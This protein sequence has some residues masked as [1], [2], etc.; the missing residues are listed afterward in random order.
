MTG[1]GNRARHL[2]SRAVDSMRCNRFSFPRRSSR[3]KKKRTNSNMVAEDFDHCLCL[4]S[5]VAVETGGSQQ[6]RFVQA[7]QVN[8]YPH[9]K[10][11]ILHPQTDGK[12][13]KIDTHYVWLWIV[14]SMGVSCTVVMH[15]WWNW[16]MSLRLKI[17]NW[18][19][20]RKLFTVMTNINK[21]HWYWN[22]QLQ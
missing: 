14:P 5:I 3:L 19:I 18:D 17:V 22:Y 12:I 21:T 1:T 16:N 4:S 6:H 11:M 2:A 8:C 9:C 10:N 15:F 13:L 7:F 20:F